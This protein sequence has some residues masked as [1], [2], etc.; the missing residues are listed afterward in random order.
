MNDER[1]QTTI[2]HVV[3]RVFLIWFVL[4]LISL[5]YRMLILK[6][7]IRDYWDIFAIFFIGSAYG[8]IAFASKGVFAH[9][10]KRTWLTLGIAASIGIF[11]VFFI[12]G[13]IHS[14]I[15]VG[16]SL[17]GLILGLGLVIGTAYFLNRRWKRKEGLEDEK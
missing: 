6:Q 9:G 15:D 11:A 3:R 17:I 1:I 2:D 7:H 5:D 13:R 12:M 10:F 8:C 4:T 14:V 16:A